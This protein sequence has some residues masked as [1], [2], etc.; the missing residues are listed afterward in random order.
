MITMYGMDKQYGLLNLND[1]KI[2]SKIILDEA[3]KLAKKLEEESYQLL[4]K[5]KDM[6][7]EIVNVL[8]EK[9]TIDGNELEEIY[10]KYC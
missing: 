4:L 2:D 9:E 7:Q 8:L 6:H 3:V 5:Y 10:Q 1:M